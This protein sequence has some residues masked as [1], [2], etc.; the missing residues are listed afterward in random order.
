MVPLC[1][2]QGAHASPRRRFSRQRLT[3][4]PRHPY[5]VAVTTPPPYPGYAA[6]P[7]VYG[8]VPPGRRPRQPVQVWDVVL[9]IVF[10]VGL[11]V[12]ALFASIAGAFLAMASDPC[13]AVTCN[14][15]LIGTGV[16]IGMVGPWLVLIAAATISIIFMVKRKLAFYLPLLGAVGVT[17]VLII[18]FFVAAA[19]VPTAG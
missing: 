12:Y 19:G 15:D 14:T 18:A 3:Q 8:A 9:T 16:L 5:D 2:H 17:G 10:L 1:A 11:V 13:G 6:Q 4:E 7:P